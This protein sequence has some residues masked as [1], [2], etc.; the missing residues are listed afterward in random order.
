M[1]L[2]AIASAGDAP[3]ATTTAFALALTWPERVLLAE[4]SPAGGRLLRGYFQCATPPDQGL[5]N[6][7]LTAVH[8]PDAALHGLWEQTLPL[9]EQQDRLL[10]PGVN[11]PFMAAQLTT[12]TWQTLAQMF[13]DL[14]LT[15]LA[16]TGPIVPELP[17]SLLR[18]ADLVIVVMRPTLAQVA[19]ARVRLERLRQALGQGMPIG[20]CVIGDRPYTPRD[21]RAQLG[22]FAL[23]L[24][25][26][27]DPRSAQVLSEG[28]TSQR[29]RRRIELGLLLRQARVT[30]HAAHRFADRQHQTLHPTPD[31]APDTASAPEDTTVEEHS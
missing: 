11:D 1:S 19:A 31:P 20:L 30:A 13:A 6:L 16:D 26:P 21:V 8:G 22:E 5:W 25:L 27:F 17:F 7:G 2:I 12:A 9:N 23:G 15:V 14:P 3:G 4:C 18:A 10:L 29:A 28:S 24:T